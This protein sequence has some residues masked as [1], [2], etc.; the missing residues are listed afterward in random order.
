MP[1]GTIGYTTT[2]DLSGLA[3]GK[4]ITATA[5]VSDVDGNSASASDKTA[6]IDVSGP[7][8]TTVIADGGDNVVN[9]SEVKAVVIS[10]TITGEV[11]AGAF[12]SMGLTG[13]RK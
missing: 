2:A 1:D 11:K 9:S 8:I 5:S 12:G 6:V 10:G 3:D 4:T 7:S 13:T